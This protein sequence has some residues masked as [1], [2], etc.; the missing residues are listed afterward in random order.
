MGV[1]LGGG[2]RG[3]PA[4]RRRVLA[5]EDGDAVETG[6]DPYDLAGGAERV[7]LAGW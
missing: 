2:R 7:E 3:R 1:P 5:E 4:E 6:A